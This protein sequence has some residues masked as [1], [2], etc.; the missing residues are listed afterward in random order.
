M[1]MDL[2]NAA[3][4]AN[5][6]RDDINRRLAEISNQNLV[7][8]VNYLNRHCRPEHGWLVTVLRLWRGCVGCGCPVC[9]VMKVIYRRRAKWILE[10]L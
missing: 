10:Q 1:I 6:S 5:C 2:G 3:A 4:A 8:R 7:E 9:R